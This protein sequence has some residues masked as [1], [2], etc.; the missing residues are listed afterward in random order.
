MITMSEPNQAEAENVTYV[1]PATAVPVLDSASLLNGQREVL[2]RHQGQ[3]YR[4]QHTRNDRL[5][6]TK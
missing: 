2:I 1:L 4:L 3:L 5:I 6:L